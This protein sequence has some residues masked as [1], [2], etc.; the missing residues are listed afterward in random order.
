MTETAILKTTHTD[1]Y[2]KITFYD[3]HELRVKENTIIIDAKAINR[4][5]GSIEQFVKFYGLE[6]VTNGA[7]V[8]ISHYCPK[9]L[10]IN[11]IDKVLNPEKFKPYDEYYAYLYIYDMTALALED[12]QQWESVNYGLLH[13]QYPFWLRAKTKKKKGMYFSRIIR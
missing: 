13:F 8:L 11:V 12:F 9:T 7:L 5:I 6:V 10:F 2:Y 4:N 1:G 3:S